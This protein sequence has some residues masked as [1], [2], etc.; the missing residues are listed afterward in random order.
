MDKKIIFFIG[1]ISGVILGIGAYKETKR[2]QNKAKAEGKHIPYGPYEVCIK[3]P[4]DLVISLFALIVLS[5]LLLTTAILVKI[6]LGSPVVFAQERPGKDGKIFKLYKFRTMSDERDENGELLQDEQRLTEFG[7]K[8][9]S[10][11]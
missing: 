9:R 4:L 3:R 8:L 2:K 10:S 6:K 1:G 5:P 7:R 11:S